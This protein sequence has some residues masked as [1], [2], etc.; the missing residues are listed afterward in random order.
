[1]GWIAAIGSFLKSILSAL[2]ILDKWFGDHRTLEDK[3]NELR[4]KNRKDVAKEQR[5][6]RPGKPWFIFILLLA[7]ATNEPMVIDGN[8]LSYILDTKKA[9]CESP[10]M[11]RAFAISEDFSALD[12]GGYVCH[13]PFVDVLIRNIVSDCEEL[14]RDL[15]DK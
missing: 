11:M 3:Q 13:S 1:M 6:G 4:K 9:R 5:D 10:P 8:S 12:A 14:V 15:R 7:C 2:P